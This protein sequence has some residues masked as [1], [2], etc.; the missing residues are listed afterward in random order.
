MVIL[1][2][3]LAI[4]AIFTSFMAAAAVFVLHV[5]ALE[6]KR[7]PLSTSTC[8][9]NHVSKSLESETGELQH[10]NYW[11]LQSHSSRIVVIWVLCRRVVITYLLVLSTSAAEVTRTCTRL[12]KPPQCLLKKKILMYYCPLMRFSHG[13]SMHN[14]LNISKAP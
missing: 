5:L 3:K 14:P 7:R 8:S 1:D 6:L 12:H 13:L 10:C 9:G 11:L 4:L 2:W